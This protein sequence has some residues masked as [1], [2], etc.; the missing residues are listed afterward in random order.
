MPNA[1]WGLDYSQGFALLLPQAGE[2]RTAAR[3]ASSAPISALAG[4]SAGAVD[5]LAD[6]MAMGQHLSSDPI[7]IV[8]LVRDAIDSMATDT[9]GDYDLLQLKGPA[10]IS[11]PPGSTTCLLAHRR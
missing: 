4:D 8:L 9:A 10:S 5:D 7:L 6:A 1:A 3:L 2:G 11:S